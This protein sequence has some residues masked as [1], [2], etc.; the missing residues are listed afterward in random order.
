MVERSRKFQYDLLS[1]ENDMMMSRVSLV[2][3]CVI[4]TT[5]L[6][7]VVVFIFG[8]RR[9]EALA[10]E[11][12][13]LSRRVTSVESVYDASECALTS[14][15]EDACDVGDGRTILLGE[16]D[17]DGEVRSLILRTKDGKTTHVGRLSRDASY[18]RMKQV[19]GSVEGFVSDTQGGSVEVYSADPALNPL[20]Q[21]ERLP[22]MMKRVL[23]MATST[24]SSP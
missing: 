15:V 12:A 24:V 14:V 23:E 2:T 4:L 19:D 8:S 1:C 5:C 9:L 3:L 18:V 16:P 17:Q 11:V 21:D 10:R 13:D 20:E 22:I 6:F 7:V